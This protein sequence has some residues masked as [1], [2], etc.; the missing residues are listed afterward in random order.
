MGKADKTAAAMEAQRTVMHQTGHVAFT[1]QQSE[2]LK[3]LYKTENRAHKL[4][5]AKEEETLRN[6]AVTIEEPPLDNIQK[7]VTQ[8]EHDVLFDGTSREGKG[9]V[10]YLNLQRKKDPKDRFL[11][12]MTSAQ[13]VGWNQ[14]LARYNASAHSRKATL[15]HTCERT[16]GI[17]NPD[18]N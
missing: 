9:R 12:P 2:V 17:F 1:H 10:Q 6:K 11:A 16:R 13:C 14:D 7:S 5:K 3:Q 18:L 15:R 8:E 4:A